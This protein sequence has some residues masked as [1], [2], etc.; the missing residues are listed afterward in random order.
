MDLAFLDYETKTNRTHKQK[1]N[2]ILFT[3]T[4]HIAYVTGSVFYIRAQLCWLI[5]FE[6]ASV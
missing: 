2:S 6:K 5:S 4:I 1:E 3:F